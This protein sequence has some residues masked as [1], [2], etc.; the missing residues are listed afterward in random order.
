M[1][2]GSR[3]RTRSAHLAAPW[4]PR[5]THRSTC[6]TDVYRRSMVV[7]WDRVRAPRN[8]SKWQVH[9]PERGSRETLTRDGL[10][11]AGIQVAELRQ[12]LVRA[13]REDEAGMPGDGPG[14]DPVHV[15][16]GGAG[17]VGREGV[18][19]SRRRSESFRLPHQLAE[20]T[21]N[22]GWLRDD[23]IPAREL[24][25]S[26]TTGPAFGRDQPGPPA[27]TNFWMRR[28]VEASPT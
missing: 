1:A 16:D 23:M 26:W 9:A 3:Y 12:V 11:G 18:V 21:R 28:P 4:A 8:T 22:Q 10:A 7:P 17:A 20:D 2:P 25:R 14:P 27:G 19:P 13:P 24:P 5:L 15:L 6:A